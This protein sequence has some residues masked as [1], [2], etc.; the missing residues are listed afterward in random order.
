M[1]TDDERITGIFSVFLPILFIDLTKVCNPSVDDP[2]WM[3]VED[4]VD[5]M[6]HKK[7]QGGD[8]TRSTDLV[9][10]LNGPCMLTIVSTCKPWCCH[11]ILLVLAH[12]FHLFNDSNSHKGKTDN[13][14]LLI[15]EWHPL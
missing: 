13:P 2:A 4:Y 10:G 5:N 14:L 3:M 6:Y 15:V 9:H 8:H 11:A 12:L 1:I 7:H